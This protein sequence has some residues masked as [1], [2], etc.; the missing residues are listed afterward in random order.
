MATVNILKSSF[1]GKLGEV[2]GT[3]QYGQDFIKAVPFSHAPHSKTQTKSVRAFEKLNRLAGGLASIAFPFLGLNNQK[4]LKHNAVAQWLKPV[5]SEKSFQPSKLADVIEV[6]DSTEISELEVDRE[7]NTIKVQARTSSVVDKKKGSAWFVVVF[8]S[9][10][11]VLIK[12]APEKDFFVGQVSTPLSNQRNYFAMAFRSDKKAG[13][14]FKHGLSLAMN[15]YVENGILYTS[16]LPD[17]E[18]WSVENEILKYIGESCEVV[19][20][21]LIIK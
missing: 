7:N 14:F 3:T 13:K 1:R 18:N 12:S 20:D 6:D 17:P 2:Y 21:M 10:G 8:D 4:M 9:F 15:L 16:R 5:I 11:S 19:G